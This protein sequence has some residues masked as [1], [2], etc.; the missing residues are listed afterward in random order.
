MI[1]S[2]ALYFYA[3]IVILVSPFH[4][5]ARLMVKGQ[6][7]TF[8]ILR[9]KIRPGE[10]Y[11]WFHAAS[12]GEFEQGRPLMERLRRLHPEYKILLTF[13]VRYNIADDVTVLESV[14]AFSFEVL[15]LKNFIEK[16]DSGNMHVSSIVPHLINVAVGTMRGILLI[17]TSG[18]K[19]AG[20]PLPL[21]NVEELLARS[22]R[23][24]M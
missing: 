11:V 24:P 10:K 22:E 14:S 13:G 18:T 21:V 8:R 12:L 23:C 20:Y 6:W 16:D 15:D 7:Q 3:L 1:Y 2:I 9:K 19:L 5:K 4:K 17:K